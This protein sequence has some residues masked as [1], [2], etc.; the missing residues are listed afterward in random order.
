MFIRSKPFSKETQKVR[1][2]IIENVRNGA[3]ISQ[4][5]IRHVGV[6]HD[7]E[8]E[9]KMR[10]YAV[11]LIAKIKQSR[12]DEIGQG[13]LF[14]HY[15]P[16]KPGRPAKKDISKILTVD[17]VVLKDL[18]ETKRIVE[19]VHDVGGHVYQQLGFNQLLGRKRDQAILQDI[20]LSRMVSPESKMG[21]QKLLCE[22]FDKHHSLDSIYRMMDKIYPNIQRIKELCFFGSKSLIPNQEVRVAFF[23]VTTLYFES[24]EVDE[25]R[26]FG[27]SKDHRFNTTQV[28]L[29]LATNE[30]G[31]PLGYEL[32]SGN[33]AEVKTLLKAID[34]WKSYLN[35]KE[36][37]FIADRAMFSKENLMVLDKSGYKYVIAAKLRGVGKKLQTEILSEDNYEPTI[38]G[39]ELAWI[40][41]FSYE[42][43]RLITS[44]KS[45]R[46][47]HDAKERNVILEKIAKTLGKQEGSSKKLVTNSGVK[48][49]TSI[50]DSKAMIDESKI[51]LDA[52]WD[53]LHGVITNDFNIKATHAIAMY[54][55]LWV[56]EESFRINKHNL[57][58]RPIFHWTKERIE[59][60]MALC[61]MSFTIL[62]HIEYKVALLQKISPREIM[63]LL[64]SVQASIL[65]HKV[66]KD[67]YRL[68]G[69]TK[70]EARK[71]YRAFN[72]TRN[73]DPEIYLN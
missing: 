47:R 13:R 23:D 14:D 31:L 54:A 55:R 59:S 37:C 24:V 2:Q 26:Q 19:G 33:T 72:L 48:K 38:L 3:K 34:N 68:P 17:Q 51:A 60:H 4:R 66:T 30:D 62:R 56:I 12:E 41:E 22:Q 5:I 35:I 53:G 27:Y 10:Q 15:G 39:N 20:V 25:L 6:A 11:E 7:A 16:S 21:L 18:K 71:I 64:L 28:V 43:K 67:Q 61:Y 9:A 42:G 50:T 8:E 32:F 63:K 29:A 45:S 65:E 1:V 49:F 36:L 73:Y 46:A 44:Y 58:M 40:G 70:N 52:A 57:E 69:V